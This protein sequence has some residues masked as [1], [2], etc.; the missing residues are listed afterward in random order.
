MKVTLTRVLET[1]KILATKVGQEIPDF[2]NYMAEFVEQIIRSLRNGLTFR[3]NFDCET[4]TARL[5]HNV[6]QNI[7]TTRQVTAIIPLRVVSQTAMLR[8]F[9]WYYDENNRLT[10]KVAF[11]ADPNSSIDVILLLLF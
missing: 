11:D 10:V 9:G 5:L 1:S 6:A 4:K 8:D 7:S 2:F 3:D